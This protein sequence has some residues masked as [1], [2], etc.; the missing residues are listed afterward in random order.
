VPN[1][2]DNLSVVF[3]FASFWLSCPGLRG[4]LK[5]EQQLGAPLS[6]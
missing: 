2:V 4:E 1:S 6:V 3:S 5:E